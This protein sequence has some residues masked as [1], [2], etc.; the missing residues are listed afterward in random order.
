MDRKSTA[1]LQE[2]M[3]GTYYGLRVGLAVIGIALPLVVL[4]A[5]GVLHH[6]WLEPSISRYYH[7]Q[8][9]ISYF[10]T[11]DLFVGGLFAVGA[12]LYLYKGFSTRENVAL[13]LAGVFAL[14]VALLPTAAT[15]G[16]EGVVSTLHKTS[17]VL[18]FL[19][20]AYVSLFRSRDTLLLLPPEKRRRYARGYLF[21][22]LAM[23]ASPLAA[24]ALSFALEPASGIRTIIF[25]LET[26]AVWS[27]AA[28]WII[29][30]VEMRKT[31]AEKR[32]LDAELKRETVSAAPPEADASR[33]GG[34]RGA[35]AL[36]S[37][38]VEAV[39][40]AD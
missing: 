8:G 40:P 37:A 13:N 31:E 33:V 21:T 14:F 29:K 10:T 32:A 26:F 24:V 22:G 11:R 34:V 28:Y 15:P 36:K 3:M 7:T 18:F 25:W 35:G 39:V 27:F 2:H 1:D 4:F 38:E 17:A 9:G 20:I 19:C 6:V 30:T 12:C 5:G 23:I 16:D